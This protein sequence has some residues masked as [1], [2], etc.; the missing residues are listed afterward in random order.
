[1]A[2][3]IPPFLMG[4]TV[5]AD[6]SPITNAL[7]KYQDAQK[8]NAQNALARDKLAEEQRQFGMQ[9][10]LAQSRFGEEQRQFGLNLDLRKQ[11]LQR[12][13]EQFGM[14][15]S[16]DKGRLDIQ[17]E[18]ARR[19]AEAQFNQQT[20]GALQRYVLEEKDPYL[21][22]QRYQKLLSSDPRFGQV[23]QRYGVDPTDHVAG[24]RV[25]IGL[26]KGYHE[27]ESYKLTELDPNKTLIGTN[28]KTGDSKIIHAPVEGPQGPY[29]DLKQ[30]ADVEE[31]LRKEVT[32]AAKDYYTVRDASQALKDIATKPS[33]GSDMAMVFSFMKILD[34]GSVVRETE[35][36]S[37]ARAAGVPERVVG[38]IE[39]IQSGQF[40]TPAQR[41]DFLGVAGT[42]ARSREGSYRQGLQRYD[43]IAKRLKVDP[44]NVVPSDAGAAENAGV[45]APGTVQDGY[46]FRGG[47]PADPASW[48]KVR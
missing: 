36:A 28:P 15:Y 29:K 4:Q 5:G 42:L 46:R 14:S 39:K 18:E 1:M 9:N 24:S 13:R 12:A 45:P 19:Q 11:E 33:A 20:A 17:K 35:Y 40:L 26:A 27:P 30:K 34:P 10:A 23:L 37:A 21:A 41:Q 3:Q 32:A 44:R 31:G 7:E 25:F 48:E 2:Y 8:F 38:I 47:N 43:D 6:F 16:L 22:Q